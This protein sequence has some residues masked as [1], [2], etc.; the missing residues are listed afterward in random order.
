MKPSQPKYAHALLLLVTS[1]SI[2]TPAMA[3][4]ASSATADNVARL[5]VVKPVSSCAALSSVDLSDLGGQGNRVLA[6][7][8][9]TRDGV[10]VC[11]VEARLA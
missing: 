5:A 11:T 10:A 3:R 8:E 1:L 2:Q 6:A 9:S 4:V 7:S